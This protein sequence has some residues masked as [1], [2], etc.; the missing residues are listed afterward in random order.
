MR[1]IYCPLSVR[2]PVIVPQVRALGGEPRKDRAL[3]CEPRKD[4]KRRRICI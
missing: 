3:G 2:G 1:G 4:S